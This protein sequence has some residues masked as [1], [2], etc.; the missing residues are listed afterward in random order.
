MIDG[1]RVASHLEAT[2]FLDVSKSVEHV[3]SGDSHLIKHEPAVILR[4][5]AELGTNIADFYAFEWQM[6]LKI[7][8][9]DEEAIDTI[10]VFTNYALS[11]NSRII[12]PQTHT[13]R[14]ELRRG[15][16]WRV[17]YELVG[18]HVESGRCLKTCDV[19][20]M[21]HL[22]LRVA[23]HPFHGPDILDPLLSLLIRAKFQQSSLEHADMQGGWI[24][25]RR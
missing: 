12:S 2:V 4:V 7:A 1:L 13:T 6:S 15:D 24:N 11:K 3:G 21:T 19:G 10:V 5:V 25:A 18:G 20:A 16:S 9:G 17:D 8:D 22:S 23:T 14:P